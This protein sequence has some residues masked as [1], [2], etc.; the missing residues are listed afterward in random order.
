[1]SVKTSLKKDFFKT[2]QKFVGFFV[3]FL[4]MAKQLLQHAELKCI[5]K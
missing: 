5:Q 1:M 3:L 4:E 2:A